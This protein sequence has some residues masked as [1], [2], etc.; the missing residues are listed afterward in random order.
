MNAGPVAPPSSAAALVA[1][2]LTLLAGFAML[3]SLPT[4]VPAGRTVYNL[5]PEFG[6][7]QNDLVWD[8][9]FLPGFNGTPE[10]HVS[11]SAP[12]GGPGRLDYLVGPW[13]NSSVAA[14]P[15]FAAGPQ[16]FNFVEV[17]RTQVYRSPLWGDYHYV[18]QG[19][20]ACAVNQGNLT[21]NAT[22]ALHPVY[23]GLPENGVDWTGRFTL[24][25]SAPVPVGDAGGVGYVALSLTTALPPVAGAVGARLVYTQILLWANAAPVLGATATGATLTE[26]AIG[27]DRFAVP[28][29]TNETPTRTFSLDLSRYLSQTLAD[30]GVDPLGAVLSYVYFD[31]G[32]YNYHLRLG[33]H[34]LFVEGPNGLCHPESL[35]AHSVVG[36]TRTSAPPAALPGRVAYG[37]ER[38]P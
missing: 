5:D 13:A 4:P 26:G 33:I 14:F 9:N 28:F 27:T 15:H 8:P 34:N 37:R 11:W 17:P 32:G 24:D 2:A 7:S 3:H 25:W 21:V 22:Q 16:A 35:A 31:V 30:L 1:G 12:Q 18:S 38:R 10:V 20:L 29:L 23:V 6:S 36:V 19:F